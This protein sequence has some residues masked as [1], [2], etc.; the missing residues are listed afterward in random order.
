M[1]RTQPLLAAQGQ[2]VDGLRSAPCAW[3]VQR[4]RRDTD[5]TH[6]NKPLPSSDKH[7]GSGEEIH[8]PMKLSLN[9]L[10]TAPM[11]QLIHLSI[12]LL[13]YIIT[14]QRTLS[15]LCGGSAM[16][17]RCLHH[18][19]RRPQPQVNCFHFAKP[20]DTREQG[21]DQNHVPLLESSTGAHASAPRAAITAA[22]KG[23]SSVQ[24]GTRSK[25]SILSPGGRQGLLNKVIP[26]RVSRQ[27]GAPVLQN[28]VGSAEYARVANAAV[29]TQ[30]AGLRQSPP[31]ILHHQRRSCSGCRATIRRQ[32]RGHGLADGRHARSGLPA[33]PADDARSGLKKLAPV[34]RGRGFARATPRPDD[35]RCSGH[36]A[37]SRRQCQARKR[38]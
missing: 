13:S 17:S 33:H 5:R 16:I 10:L 26:W 30:H 23:A 8:F 36:L 6:C 9:W 37:R 29:R 12:L 21:A 18:Q 24:A 20:A 3:V 32:L 25:N 28:T 11:R 14:Q 4:A 27:L 38:G 7:A 35:P 19:S 2:P 1:V 15:H 31:S 22:S 34:S